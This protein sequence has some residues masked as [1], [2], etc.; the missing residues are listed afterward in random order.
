MNTLAVSGYITILAAAEENDSG[1]NWVPLIAQ[2]L[3][4]AGVVITVLWGARHQR[5]QPLVDEATAEHTEI[6]GDRLRQTIEDMN[7]KSNARRDLRLAQ[8]HSYLLMDSEW[9]YVVINNERK[10][11]AVVR[12]LVALLDGLKADITHII[13][14]DLSPPPPAVPEPPPAMAG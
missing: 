3:V 14:P 8:F 5:R 13:I 12:E 1:I 2:V 7:E 9:H 6:D 11:L 10:L 4:L